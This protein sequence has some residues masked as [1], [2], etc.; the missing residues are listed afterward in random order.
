MKE[1][2]FFNQLAPT[3]L[4]IKNLARKVDCDIY[5]AATTR[6]LATG[7]YHL[8]IQRLDRE[9]F[10]QDDRASATYLNSSIEEFILPAVEQY[11]WPYRRFE[12]NVYNA[13]S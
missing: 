5:I 4:L 6:H 11:Q 8:D 7:H 2:P 9:K 12:R 13:L 10:L 3:S 1:A